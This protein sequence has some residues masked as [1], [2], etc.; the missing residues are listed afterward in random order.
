MK[1]E[2][3]AGFV[4]NK[5]FLVAT[6]LKKTALVI[7]LIFTT[8]LI[9]YSQAVTEVITDF[10]GY[11]K[12]S[13]STPNA[14]KPD[15]SHNLLAFRYNNILYS[16]GVN[17]EL[18]AT[19]GETFQVEDFWCLPVSGL[20]GAITGNTKV[21]LGAL[22]DGAANGPGTTPPEWGIERY[23][24]DGI[25]GLDMGTCIANLPSGL[26]WFS[27]ANIQAASIGDGIPDV[28]VTQIADPSGS[29]D[30]YEFTDANGVRVG[31]YKDIVFTNI[32]PVGNWTADFYEAS[33][34]PMT[35]SG[36]FAQTDRPIRLWA[37]D[38]SDFGITAENCGQIRNFQITL[39]GNSDVAFVAYNNTSIKL[40]TPLPVQYA[41]FSATAFQEKIKLDWQTTSEQN[42]ARFIVE[43]SADG[44]S[45]TSIGSVPAK[46][47][48]YNT[49]SFLDNDPLSGKN[50]Y[51]L[52]QVD[53]NRH[54]KIS[55][56]VI[57]NNAPKNN[58]NIYPNPAKDV[59][60]LKH[61]RAIGD[62]ILSLANA[63]GITL[64]QVR[65]LKNEE[66]SKLDLKDLSA[67][68]YF[69]SYQTKN[70][71]QVSTFVIR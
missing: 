23:L 65:V 69:I 64:R 19:N 21:G 24:T 60:Y 4:I 2:T 20:T 41:S 5:A 31:N 25:K 26:M 49:Y 38:L 55:F 61:D 36:G 30:R 58:L 35:L 54:F 34:N 22:Y 8:S 42:A 70:Q 11:W 10:H 12:S 51:R 66:V 68:T 71:K 33:K 56:V 32:A 46:N 17:N 27:V 37:A 18:L 3:A 9:S 45:F 52:K 63:A 7:L 57:V 29:F 53:N 47:E 13:A 28:L 15:N 39:C 67:G 43:R 16:T 59:L 50:Y 40:Q 62:E 48:A 14:I 1:I 44:I 6:R